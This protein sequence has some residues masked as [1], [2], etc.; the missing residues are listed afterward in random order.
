MVEIKEHVFRKE[1]AKTVRYETGSGMFDRTGIAEEILVTE[2]KLV[3]YDGKVTLVVPF[4]HQVLVIKDGEMLETF[5]GG[6]HLI[7]DVKV[8]K[9]G[10]FRK[11]VPVYELCPI[12]YFDHCTTD[13]PF[14]CLIYTQNEA[15]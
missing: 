10:L 7:T 6:K 13:H 12:G 9:V 11:E 5:S 2:D 8:S 4:A 15:S 3:D 14:C 1:N